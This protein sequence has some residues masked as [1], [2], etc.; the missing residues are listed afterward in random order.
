MIKSRC[1]WLGSIYNVSMQVIML[2]QYGSEM[3]LSDKKAKC[4]TSLCKN[5]LVLCVW[6][7]QRRVSLLVMIW[8][9]KQRIY[10]S[11]WMSSLGRFKCM[12]RFVGLFS[13][14]Q[15]AMS[16]ELKV[17]RWVENKC[18]WNDNDRS[19]P[20][21][22]CPHMLRYAELEH[23]ASHHPW[24]CGWEFLMSQRASEDQST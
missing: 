15:C 4:Y 13:S 7:R 5:K 20:I 9:F 11:W 14:N 22:I 6:V 2:V 1:C 19:F 18:W 21:C 16:W 10:R 12:Y 8:R 3:Y 24:V 17:V 23:L